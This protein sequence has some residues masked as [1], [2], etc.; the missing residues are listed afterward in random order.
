MQSNDIIF[1]ETIVKSMVDNNSEIPERLSNL[2]VHIKGNQID[3]SFDA[4]MANAIYQLQQNIYRLV[5]KTLYGNDATVAS[6]NEDEL[7]KFKL[8]FLVSAGSTNIE[9]SLWEKVVELVDKVTIDMTPNQK[10]TLAVIIA[11]AIIG[12]NGVNEYFAYKK[13]ELSSSETVQLSQ[14]ETKRIETI[15]NRATEVGSESANAFVKAAKGAKSLSFGEREYNEKDIRDAQKRAP[16]T[17]LQWSEISGNH[18]VTSLDCTKQGTFSFV[19]VDVHSRQQIKAYYPIEDDDDS[20]Q[21]VRI[22][23][24]ES[25]ATGKAVF[26]HLNVGKKDG[27]IKKV[28]L[29]DCSE[30]KK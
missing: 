20:A 1:F 5:A 9:T 4:Q 23:L 12:V 22:V 3:G 27:E 2:T 15:V 29:L 14:E 13:E 7:E 25:L 17:S 28:I 18:V 16:R 11:A 30:S 19:A 8:T 10:L 24:A 6:L 21:D 26:L